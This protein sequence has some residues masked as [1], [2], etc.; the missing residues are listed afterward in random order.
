MIILSLREYLFALGFMIQVLSPK[1]TVQ[2]TEHCPVLSKMDTHTPNTHCLY[3]LD[4]LYCWLAAPLS[5]ASRGSRQ[6]IACSSASLFPLFTSTFA[7]ANISSR[8][9]RR[10]FRSP[11]SRTHYLLSLSLN[12]STLEDKLETESWRSLF[13]SFPHVGLSL[14]LLFRSLWSCFS[15][16]ITISISITSSS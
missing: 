8:Y 3:S 1:Y 14:W 11:H 4:H 15:A 16:S 10:R 13:D 9:S 6:W 2:S 12:Q 7:F 5:S